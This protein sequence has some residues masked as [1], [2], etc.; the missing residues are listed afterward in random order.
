[1][2]TVND[3]VRW[4]TSILKIQICYFLSWNINHFLSLIL[5][6]LEVGLTFVSFSCSLILIMH[7]FLIPTYQKI[8]WRKKKTGKTFS[9]DT[10]LC[11]QAFIL[12]KN[13]QCFWLLTVSGFC[14]N[15]TINHENWYYWLKL[16]KIL[17][18]YFLFVL[19]FSFYYSK[20]FYSSCT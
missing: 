14:S 1:M 18:F 10:F 8:E 7:F 3:L 11:C 4:F 15:D 20:L 19:K 16:V 5:L 17:N 6:S 9:E 12:L 13:Y 2:S